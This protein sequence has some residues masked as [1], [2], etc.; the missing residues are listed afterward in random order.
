MRSDLKKDLQEL[1]DDKRSYL[2]QGKAFDYL[3]RIKFNE[4]LNNDSLKIYADWFLALTMF[5]PS[6]GR[7]E[8][9]KSSGR[10]G[11]I[12]EYELQNNIVD[13]YQEDMTQLVAITN[14]YAAQKKSFFA[15]L[16]THKKRLT[17]STTNLADILITEEARNL[18]ARLNQTSVIVELYDICI[19]RIK[20]IVSQIEGKYNLPK[21]L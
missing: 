13:L 1:R 18:Y 12:Q 15:Y 11:N 4:S 8:G 2:S 19:G 9:F 14:L 5:L 16:D 10:I 3:T 7:F 6:N 20:V 17:D 21:E